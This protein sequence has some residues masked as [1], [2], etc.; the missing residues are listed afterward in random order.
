MECR[1]CLGHVREEA[2]PKCQHCVHATLSLGRTVSPAQSGS[3]RCPRLDPRGPSPPCRVPR[4]GPDDRGR[5]GQVSSGQT[6]WAGTAVNFDDLHHQWPRFCARQITLNH[7]LGTST[8]TWAPP[9]PPPDGSLSHTH[10]TLRE[11]SRLLG[12]LVVDHVLFSTADSRLHFFDRVAFAASNSTHART[13]A[14]PEWPAS[15]P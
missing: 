9:P 2:K 12:S 1:G 13:P 14:Q 7:H 15:Q 4:S 10:T 8:T 11:I 6:T 3:R 5:A